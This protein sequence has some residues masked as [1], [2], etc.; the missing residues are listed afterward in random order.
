MSYQETRTGASIFSGALILAAYC[1]YAFNPARLATLAPDDL[2][3]W[4]TTMLIFIAIGIGAAIVIQIVFHILYSIGLAV[5][6]KIEDQH[7]DDQEIERSIKREMVE[8]ERDRQIE[9]K[10]MRIGF[11]VAGIG[12]VGGLFS[13]VFNYSPVVMLNIL[14]LSFMIGSLLE[15]AGRLFYYRRGG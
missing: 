3:P 15:G 7:S 2:K 10:S 1:I 6:S 8:D 13:L 14:Y 12:F 5:R 9:L 4:A 11:I